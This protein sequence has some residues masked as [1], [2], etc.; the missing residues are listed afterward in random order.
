MTGADLQRSR[1]PEGVATHVLSAVRRLRPP[2]SSRQFWLVQAG[3]LLVAFV[4]EIVLDYM[5]VRLP[6]GIPS[7]AITALLLIPII[8][9]AMNF[10]VR[11]GVGTA[12]WA[13]AILV[14]DRVFLSHMTRTNM[15]VEVGNLAILNGV[16]IVVGQRVER[17]GLARRRAEDALRDSAAAE[18]RYR[19]LFEEQHAPVIVTDA[20]GAVTEANAAA[21]SLLGDDLPGRLLSDLVATSVTA[22]LAGTVQRLSVGDRVFVPKA[23]TLD[24]GTGESLVQIVL[25]DATEEE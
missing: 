20:A 11:G 6:F 15:W 23:R 14:P 4:D 13:T 17:E 1:P 19:A 12:L 22:V 16:A 3:V 5:G 10:G 9:A 8:Y 24:V 21:T 18:T 25:V 2:V 7:A